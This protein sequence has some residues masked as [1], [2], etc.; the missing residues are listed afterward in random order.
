MATLLLGKLNV[1]LARF[2]ADINTCN[3]CL[4]PGKLSQCFGIRK[5]RCKFALSFLK[6]VYWLYYQ[7]AFCL[8]IKRFTDK[9]NPLS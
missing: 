6:N 7:A 4:V 8:H 5:I 9:R 3:Y 1:T 2:V